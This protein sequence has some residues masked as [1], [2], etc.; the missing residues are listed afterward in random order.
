MDIYLTAL[1]LGGVGLVGMA[2]G[3]FGRHGHGGHS[4]HAHVGGAG[5]AAGHGTAH[6]PGSAHSHGHAAGHTPGSTNPF[7]ALMS[8]RVLFSILLG[9][10]TAGVVLRDFLSGP[11]LFAAALGV[12]I[13]FERILVAPL[14]NFAFRFA[15]NPAATL[16]GSVMD[17]A[18]AVTAFD[19][20]GQGLIAIEVDGQMVQLL[21]TLQAA[22]K[23]MK[24][25]VP[26]GSRLR[27]QEVDAARNRCTVS[28]I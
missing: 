21:G 9:L 7:V 2:V 16:E 24:V 12:G 18:T 23:E 28:L 22:D 1:A 6:V 5:H 10:G 25:R 11:L 15:S 27:I 13:L 17:E 8:P 4:G 14:W 3:G 26:A 20:N 19:K